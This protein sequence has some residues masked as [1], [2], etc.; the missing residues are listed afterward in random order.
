MKRL[1]TALAAL[2]GGVAAYLL[3]D[4]FVVGLI[5]SAFGVWLLRNLSPTPVR[6]AQRE[7]VPRPSPRRPRE[8]GIHVVCKQATPL[9]QEW[10]SLKTGRLYD[11]LSGAGLPNAQP[12]DLGRVMVD[13]SGYRIRPLE[14]DERERA[15]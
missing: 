5:A 12:G 3:T 4:Q 15:R 2:A 13:N 1:P 11:V 6:P 8:T 14:A 7:S 10:V 9:R